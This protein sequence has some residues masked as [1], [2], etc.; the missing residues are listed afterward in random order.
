MIGSLPAHEMG[1]LLRGLLD[2]IGPHPVQGGTLDALLP[3]PPE[4]GPLTPAAVLFP[5]TLGPHGAEVVLTVRNAGLRRHAGQIS[6]PGGKADPEDRDV[7]HT[8]AREAAEEIGLMESDIQVL[9]ALDPCV[10]GTGFRVVPV[11]GLVPWDYAYK[12]DAREVSEIFHVP[13]DFVLDAT[14][15]ERRSGEFNGQRREYYAID[16]ERFHIWGAT[17]RMIVSLHA[18]LSRHFATI[19]PQDRRSICDNA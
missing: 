17:A 1:P 16:Y 4:T 3:A 14:R 13:L 12:P 9:G 6:F 15:H 7:A 11:I 10:T 2:P 8:A 19:P 5:L 18:R